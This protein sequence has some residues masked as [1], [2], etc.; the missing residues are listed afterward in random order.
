VNEA[1]KFFWRSVILGTIAC[2]VLLVGIGTLVA[3]GFVGVV[4][5]LFSVPL[6][7]FSLKAE[8]KYRA[9]L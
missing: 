1:G 9:C 8:R 3:N 7:Y 5:C 6:L 2:S 4:I